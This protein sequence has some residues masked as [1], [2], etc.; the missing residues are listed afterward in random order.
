MDSLIKL[1]SKEI[2]S[3]GNHIVKTRIDIIGHIHFLIA[4][5]LMKHWARVDKRMVVI[6]PTFSYYQKGIVNIA[7][8][9]RTAK[10]SEISKFKLVDVSHCHRSSMS[11]V[12]KESPLRSKF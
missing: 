9:Y 1:N 2:S 12:H 7:C 4:K 6:D 3:T 11:S 10:V 8:D 5:V